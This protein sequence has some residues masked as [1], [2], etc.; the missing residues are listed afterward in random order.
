M[1][2]TKYVFQKVQGIHG[3]NKVKSKVN[4]F[5]TILSVFIVYKDKHNQQHLYLWPRRGVN[6]LKSVR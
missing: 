6:T 3:V 1:I 2:V 5:L 4:F